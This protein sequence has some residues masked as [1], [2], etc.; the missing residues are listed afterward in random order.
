VANQGTALRIYILP[1]PLFYTALAACVASPT[2][3][4][5]PDYTAIPTRT[6][7]PPALT[8]SHCVSGEPMPVGDLPGWRQ[9]FADDFAGTVE[10]GE[11]SNCTLSPFV[12]SGLPERYRARWWAY[13]EVW[14]DTSKNG[15]YSPSKVLS[16]ADGVLD[17]YV[18]TED[19]VHRV[20]APMPLIHGKDGPLGQLHGRYA[21]RFRTDSLPGYKIA[22]LLWPDSKA[23][24]RDGE[25]DFPEANLD[26]EI[27][28]FMHRQDATAANDQD[29]FF[30]GIDVTSG[31][32]T[33][34]IEWTDESVRFIL[35][36]ALLGESIGRIPDTPMHWVIQTE[37]NLDGYEPDDGVAG[38]VQIDWVAVYSVE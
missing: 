1:V 2:A 24:P 8:T 3:T 28:A 19:G 36:D 23:W 27:C 37:T 26:G 16:V 35:D 21:I 29:A 4:L 33:A 15:T 7:S 30:S 17:L 10:L 11:W 32:H 9:V 13:A 31:W 25:I 6:L 14:P 18:H 22:W 20:A 34:V 38:H 5:P 12:C